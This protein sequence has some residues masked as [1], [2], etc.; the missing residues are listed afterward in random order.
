VRSLQAA[1]HL[2]PGFN[3]EHAAAISFDVGLEG[4]DEAKGRAFYK[5]VVEH[6]RA[7]PGV[8]SA[9]LTES[10]PLSI[11]YNSTSIYLEGQAAKGMS[12]LPSAVPRDVGPDYFRAMEIPLRGRD[13]L[14]NEDRKESRVAVVSETFAHRFF[15]GKEAIGKRFNFSGPS[16][17]YWEI[18]GVCADGKYNS[19]GEEPIPAVY[20]PLLRDYVTPVTLVARGEGSAER[21]LHA[22]KEGTQRLDPHLTIYLATTLE[23]HMDIPLFPARMAAEALGS[24]GLLALILAAV[25]IYGVMSYIVAGRTREIGVRMALGAQAGSIRG[26]ILRQGMLLACIGALLGLTISFGATRLLDSLLYGVNAVDLTTF[27]IVT[28][29]LG[30]VALLACWFPAHRAT[31]VDPMVALRAE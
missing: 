10:L 31:R 29:L 8:T 15:P 1:Q 20:R 26:L 24:F 27:A 16:D 25:G 23:E 18:I 7:L 28:F 13:F 12:Q 4:Y 22:L 6:A 30:T 17:P 11:D 21:I 3:P 5:T 2:H 19:L 14:P 9:A